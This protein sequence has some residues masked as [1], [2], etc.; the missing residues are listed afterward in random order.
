MAETGPAAMIYHL[1]VLQH[2]HAERQE[3]PAKP[4]LE[5][6]RSISTL[7]RKEYPRIRLFVYA[8]VEALSHIIEKAMEDGRVDIDGIYTSCRVKGGGRQV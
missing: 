1:G 3:P 6:I 7:L 5:R 2:F 4:Y 8:R